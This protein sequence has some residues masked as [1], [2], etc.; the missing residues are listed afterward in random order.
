MGLGWVNNNRYT[1]NQLIE[2][3]IPSHDINYNDICFKGYKYGRTLDEEGKLHEYSLNKY[4][5]SNFEKSNPKELSGGMRQRVALIR[6]LAI[7]PDIL[8]LDEPFSALDYQTKIIVSDDI[9]KIIKESK[10]N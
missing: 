4:E 8:L 2:S 7:K 9:F 6:T 10:K 1:I 3:E 5:L